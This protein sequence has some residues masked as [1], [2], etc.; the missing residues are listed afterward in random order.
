[1]D[2]LPLEHAFLK[3]PCEQQS[4][5]FRVRKRAVQKEL[6]TLGVLVEQLGENPSAS[7]LLPVAKRLGLFQVVLEDTRQEERSATRLCDSRLRHLRE[8]SSGKSGGGGGGSGGSGGSHRHSSDSNDDA[9]L[10]SA[11]DE[12]RLDRMLVDYMLRA[13]MHET[14]EK[15]ADARDIRPLVELD[16]FSASRTIVDALRE[17]D[18]A[19]A[20]RWCAENRRRLAKVQ[21]TLEFRLRLQEFVE[22][23]RKGEKAHA[24]K[25]VRNH[26]MPLTADSVRGPDIQRS[27]ALLAFGPD[28]DC[29]PYKDMYADERWTELVH[30]F[31]SDNYRLHG[32]P[33]ESLLEI[34]LKSG[35]SSLK[36]RQCGQP[37][38]TN[39]NCPTC[40]EPFRTLAH[41]L[42]RAQHVHSVLVCHITKK[43]MDENN[44]PMVLPNGNVYSN[45][46]LIRIA[47]QNDGKVI[48]PRTGEQFD[49][50]ELR[51]CFI[52]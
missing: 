10:S 49:V 30:A 20:L 43:A 16:I 19:P 12:T 15:L 22:L 31:N 29:Q 1:M 41:D 26:L 8:R 25:Y 39:L 51:K 17:R 45:E 3:A 36:N 33:R 48:D 27:M 28:T 11:W 42:P 24:I 7:D 38:A 23:A 37:E 21:S 32:L 9:P 2:D 46:S 18:C 40:I 14:A 47:A 35:L 6:D 13:G 4:K 44:P 5:L 50:K 34:V 52:M